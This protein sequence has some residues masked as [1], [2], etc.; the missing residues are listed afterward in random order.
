MKININHIH[1]QAAGN[2]LT[3]TINQ[4]WDSS[5]HILWLIADLFCNISRFPFSIFT[6]I[7]K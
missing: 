7:Q 2:N 1:S 6:N 4:S 3:N 5:A